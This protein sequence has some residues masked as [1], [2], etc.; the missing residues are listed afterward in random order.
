MSVCLR[1]AVSEQKYAM[2]LMPF[3]VKL[4]LNAEGALVI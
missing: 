3:M 4:E 2:S 1:E